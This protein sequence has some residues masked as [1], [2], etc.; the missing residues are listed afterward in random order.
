M[1]LLLMGPRHIAVPKEHVIGFLLVEI[2][3]DGTCC[4][5]EVI[6]R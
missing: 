1:A 4:A 6:T 5:K 2:R 3:P